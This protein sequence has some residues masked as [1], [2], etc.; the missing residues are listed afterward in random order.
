MKNNLLDTSI[1][2]NFSEDEIN[3]ISNLYDM[4]SKTYNLEILNAATERVEN[5]NNQV[6]TVNT[7]QLKGDNALELFKKFSQKVKDEYI[8]IYRFGI[9]RIFDEKVY[10]VRVATCPEIKIEGYKFSREYFDEITSIISE[11]DL[12][13]FISSKFI[14]AK[15]LTKTFEYTIS[16]IDDFKLI[17]ERKLLEVN[18]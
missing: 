12:R 6:V 10:T 2:Q 18:K 7:Y 1:G 3:I 11:K 13:N 4:I 14:S 17:V 8:A 9:V 15:F 5:W 16:K